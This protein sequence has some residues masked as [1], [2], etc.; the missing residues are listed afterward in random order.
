VGLDVKAFRT[1][2]QELAWKHLQS[3][4]EIFL[5]LVEVSR[6]IDRQEW[7]SYVAAR[8]YEGLELFILRNLMGVHT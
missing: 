6:R 3:S 1:Q 4:K 7:Q 2:P 8:D 5:Q